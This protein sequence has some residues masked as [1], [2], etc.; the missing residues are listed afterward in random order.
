MRPHKLE[1]PPNHVYPPEEWRLVEKSFYPRIIGR[2]ETL[3][4]VSNGYI[5]IR[6][7]FEEGRPVKEPATFINGFHETWPITYGEAAFG[8]AKTGQTML[9][10]PEAT[11]IRL[12]VDD[13][14]LNLSTARLLRF[15]RA[16]DMR[17][18]TLDRTVVWE[19]P[20][21]KQVMIRSKRLVSLT[22][23]H[24]A[25]MLFEVTLLNRPAPI[26]I[27]SEVVYRTGQETDAQLDPRQSRSFAGRVLVP[28]ARRAHADRVILAHRTRCSGMSIASGIDHVIESEADVMRRRTD[29]EDV[30]KIVFSVEGEPD[31]PVRLSKFITYHTSVAYGAEELLDRSERTLDR[32]TARGFQPHLDQQRQYLD[33]FWSRSDVLIEGL[34]RLQQVVRLNLFHVIQAAARTDERGVPAKGLTGHGYEGHCF[35]DTEIYV[36]PFLDYT[37]PQIAYNLLRF[38]VAMLDAAR[39]RAADVNQRGALFP[40][41]TINGEEAS[42][43]YAAGTAQYH[44]NA[45]VV[46]AIRK[47]VNATGDIDFLCRD[48]APVLVETARLWLDLGFYSDNGDKSFRIHGVTGPDEYNTVVNNNTFTNLMARENL[49]YA[50][51]S[52]VKMRAEHPDLYEDLVHKT[53]LKDGEADQWQHA[54]DHMFVPYDEERGVHLQDDQFLDREPWDFAGT[55][56]ER[57]PLLLH[58]H[59]LVIYRHQVIKQADVVLAMFLLGDSFSAEQKRKNFDHYDPLTTGDSSLSACIQAIMATEVGHREKAGV[60]S[61]Y[62]MLM[63]LADVSGNVADG[64]HIA[65]MGGSWMAVVYGFAGFRDHSGRPSFRPRRIDEI[66]R[67]A[68]SLRIGPATLRVD[69]RTQE[70]RYSLDDGDALTI[71]HGDEEITLTQSEPTA[72]RPTFDWDD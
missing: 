42:A 67:F 2:M 37:S 32:I 41:R 68:F 10:V 36:L 60:Y 43:Y 25:A 17:A 6:G 63:D 66:T 31:K 9:A 1:V 45:D 65:S 15:E 8:F 62:A 58:Y 30:G 69:I 61:R 56:P 59:P 19:T 33:E 24:V 49:R 72:A 38:R 55:P 13:E 51:E 53:D 20:A 28:T 47:Y 35:W 4:T 46:Y 44:I 52:V 57:Y 34:P 5:G 3:F 16:L 71:W 23:R 50:A 40:W 64:C 21:G 11:S 27:A 54:A 39:R 70:A 12:Y 18:G 48:A 22:D 7:S 14:P 26:A 29:S